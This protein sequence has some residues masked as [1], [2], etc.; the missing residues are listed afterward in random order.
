M[1][2]AQ[3]LSLIELERYLERAAKRPSLIQPPPL[4]FTEL[5]VVIPCYKEEKLLLTL[6]SLK[7]SNSIKPAI[8]VLIVF[9][10]SS[11]DI[12]ARELNQKQKLVVEQ[13]LEKESDL[14]F[15]LYCIEEHDLDPKTAGVGIARKIGMDEAVRRFLQIQKSD[16]IIA[17]LDA[18]C[19]VAPNYFEAILEGFAENPKSEAAALYFEHPLEGESHS[20]EIYSA[21]LYYEL[22]LRY[23]KHAMRFA[24]LPFD[25]Y[26]VGSSMAVKAFAY[27]K[28]GGMNQRKAGEDFYFLQKYLVNQKLFNLNTTAVYPSPRVSERVPFGTGRAV[29]DHQLDRKNLHESYSHQSFELI[30]KMMYRI[31]ETYPK[32]PQAEPLFLEFLGVE[33]WEAKWQEVFFQTNDWTSFQ[34]RLHQWLTPFKLLKFIHFLRDH[35]FANEPIEN[36][37]SMLLDVRSKDARGMLLE[38]REKDKA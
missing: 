17:C 9:N 1:A 14:P 10:A 7:A 3:T 6:E 36:A 15:Q 8:E 2:K 29:L 33:S 37:V 11:E 28:E 31:K 23:F 25:Y 18:D 20:E 21:I 32:C 12:E 27:A 24:Q 13:W 4:S 19:T 16:G 30:A 35:Q 5:I 38:L 26:T 22:H 34:K